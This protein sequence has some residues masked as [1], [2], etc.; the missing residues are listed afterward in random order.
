MLVAPLT[1]LCIEDTHYPMKTGHL[2]GTKSDVKH[3]EIV[4]NVEKHCKHHSIHTEK[5]VR[6]LVTTISAT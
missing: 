4:E 6:S 1:S 3:N 5:D 2:I